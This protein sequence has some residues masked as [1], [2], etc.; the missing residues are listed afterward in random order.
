VRINDDDDD[1]DDDDG[2]PERLDPPVIVVIP[3]FT[4]PLIP[5]HSIPIQPVNMIW[6]IF[7]WLRDVYIGMR[8]GDIYH[9]VTRYYTNVITPV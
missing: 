5:V 7:F 9:E 2:Q 8:L 6:N 1:D 4:L 3:I